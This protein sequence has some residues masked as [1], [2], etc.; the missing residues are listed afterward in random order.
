MAVVA[1]LR[2]VAV[3]A[4]VLV[5]VIHRRLR[6]RMARETRER[7]RVAARVTVRTADV[8]VSREREL[9]VQRRSGPL[10]GRVAVLAGLRICHRDVARGPLIVRGVTGVTRS[11]PA[12]Q[13]AVAER[14]SHPGVRVV[15]ILAGLREAH[16]RV[17]GRRLIF[18]QVARR[19]VAR[20]S[21]Y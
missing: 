18:W 5:L 20:P 15:T 11:G 1:S 19:A 10:R 2:T 4:S 21:R 7:R 3:P 17:V 8:M 9:V 13:S 14:R 6:V 16:S 12:G